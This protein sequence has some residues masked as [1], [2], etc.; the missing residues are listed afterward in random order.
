ML[1][2]RKRHEGVAVS[3][4]VPEETLLLPMDAML[5]EQVLLNSYDREVTS[6]YIGGL[7][8]TESETTVLIYGR[9]GWPHLV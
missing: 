4:S 6:V 1:N 5:I 8:V 3:V 2:F 7:H 9:K